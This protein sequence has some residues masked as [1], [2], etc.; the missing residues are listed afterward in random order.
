MSL[1]AVPFL[2]WAG[3]KAKLAAAIDGYLPRKFDTYY[4]PFLGGGA[5]FWHLAFNHRF[6]HAVLN[7]ANKEL[8]DCYRVI[9][10][11]PDD[12]ITA[13]QNVE[14]QY[15]LAPK[16]TFE[17]WKALDPAKLDPV[18]RTV[19]TILLNKTGFNGLYRINQSGIFNVPWGKREKIRLMTHGEEGV[20][21]CSETLNKHVSLLSTDFDAA[22]SWA[23][24]E[25]DVVYLDPPYVP[26]SKTANFTSYT[27]G[28]FSTADQHRVVVLFEGLVARGVKVIASNADLPQVREMYKGFEMHEVRVARAINCAGNKRGKVGELIIIGRRAGKPIWATE[29][30][31]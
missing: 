17:Q 24:G 29:A 15:N 22:C 5:V 7:D 21:S 14:A 8:M 12:I 25:N 6:K 23:A 18:G 9:R 27:D 13:L 30:L 26:V 19:R 3:G 4:E 2:K 11:F 20:R 1:L 28:K 31:P 16:P 10:D